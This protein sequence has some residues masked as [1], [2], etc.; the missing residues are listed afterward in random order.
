MQNSLAVEPSN[1]QRSKVRASAGKQP[2]ADRED[3][4]EGAES[5]EE[6]AEDD[7][8][9]VAAADSQGFWEALEIIDETREQYFIRWAGTDE[10]GKP[11]PPSWVSVHDLS[12]LFQGMKRNVD[13][14]PLW[15]PGTEIECERETDRSVENR[16]SAEAEGEER[17]REGGSADEKARGEGT[18]ARERLGE[19][20]TSERE[21]DHEN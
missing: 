10:R 2:H 5:Q 9:D 7:E 15:F 11:W 19:T 21:K 8:A 4:S 6:E 12:L 14:S 20:E 13:A 1:T 17:S 16:R 18:E 3:D